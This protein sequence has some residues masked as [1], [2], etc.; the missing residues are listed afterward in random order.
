MLGAHIHHQAADDVGDAFVEASEPV[1]GGMEP[2]EI[3]ITTAA[4]DG[5]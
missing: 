4:I 2:S 3:E 1:V 5:P